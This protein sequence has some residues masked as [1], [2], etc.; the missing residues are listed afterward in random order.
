MLFHKNAPTHRGACLVL[1]LLAAGLLLFVT[2]LSFM[3]LFLAHV[4]AQGLAFGTTAGSL[5]ILAFSVSLMLFLHHLRSCMAP[6]EMCAVITKA[7]KK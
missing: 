4:D 7:K 2:L 5:S 3:G 6:C 1:H